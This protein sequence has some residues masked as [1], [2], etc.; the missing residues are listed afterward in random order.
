MTPK[1]CAVQGC[2][3]KVD[4]IVEGDDIRTGKPLPTAYACDDPAHQYAV[5]LAIMPSGQ[6]A[7]P[8]SFGE[9]VRRQLAAWNEASR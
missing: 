9:R 1:R 4:T 6:L 3:R 8:D 7:P 5:A 2:R